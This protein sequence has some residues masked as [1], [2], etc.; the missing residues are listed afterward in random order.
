VLFVANFYPDKIN[1]FFAAP[2]RAGKAA[3]ANVVGTGASFTCGSFIRFYLEIDAST[4]EIHDARYQTNGC[5][6]AI[7]AAEI[8]AEKIIGRKLTDLHGLNDAEFFGEIEYEL[9]EFSSDR[10]HCARIG[11]DAMQ[12]AFGDFRALQIEEF[13]GE[14]ALICTCFGVSE[15]T[16]ESVIAENHAETVEEVGAICNAGTGCGSCQFLIQELIDVHDL[17]F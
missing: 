17:E 16:I 9:G 7:A 13:A 14:K 12:A 3:R 5:G 8:T 11:F 15:E 1:A 2:K 4:K 10:K 6:F